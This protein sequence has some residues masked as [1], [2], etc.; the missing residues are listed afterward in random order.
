[1]ISETSVTYTVGENVIL[2]CETSLEHAVEWT[3]VERQGDAALVVYISGFVINGY[4]GR[5]SV[6]TSVQHV[7]NLVIRNISL[8]DAGIYTC[9]DDD[10]FG[11]ERLFRVSVK[12][13]GS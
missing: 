13:P 1:V 4:R 3:H 12:L 6:D 11:D 10:G 8:P 5:F 9:I 7:Y 2:S